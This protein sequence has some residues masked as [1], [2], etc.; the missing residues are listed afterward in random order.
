[1]WWKNDKVQ[2][3]LEVKIEIIVDYLKPEHTSDY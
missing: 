2:T 1:M 3:I